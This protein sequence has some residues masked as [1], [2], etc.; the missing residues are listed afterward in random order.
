M[1]RSF[2]ALTAS[3][4]V[5]GGSLLGFAVGAL[6]IE[7]Y[8]SVGVLSVDLDLAS[9]K[10]AYEV[11]SNAETI[12][13]YLSGTN[14]DSRAKQLILTHAAGRDPLKDIVQPLYRATRAD[15]RDLGDFRD[16]A[17]KGG[18]ALP[19]L[20]LR[21]RV[22]SAEASLARDAALLLAEMIRDVALWDSTINFVVGRSAE[23]EELL[24][25][26]EAELIKQEFAIAEAGRKVS[27]LKQLVKKYPSAV[28]AESRQ[29]VNVDNGAER[30]LSPTT[31][32]V[33]EEAR[34]IDLKK[35]Q[36]RLER[37]RRQLE[38]ERALVA[39]L[40]ESGSRPLHGRELNERFRHAV[41]DALGAVHPE[42]D[43]TR[44]VQKGYLAELTALHTQWL[45]RTR[46]LAGPTLPDEP[47]G[48]HRIH[49][50]LAVGT[51]SS[52]LALAFWSWPDFRRRLDALRDALGIGQSA[53]L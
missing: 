45:E 21:I 50:A 24:L 32:I 17:K 29:V 36:Q 25:R 30:F 31:Q 37:R 34:V 46:F 27:E 52:A 20:G 26:T 41:S 10:R 19:I 11:L 6:F 2:R 47:T 49:S 22:S 53:R 38:A 1:K 42:D 33:A 3:A 23:I 12:K 28:T 15:V 35:E 9:Y 43:T 8:E 4:I 16:A 48:F 51:L 44:E 18:Q 7:R 13:V 39:Q 5:I 40:R 14:E